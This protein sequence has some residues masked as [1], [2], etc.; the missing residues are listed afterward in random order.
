MLMASFRING[1]AEKDF[2]KWKVS[3]TF[4]VADRSVLYIC[5]RELCGRKFIFDYSIGYIFQK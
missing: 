4:T 1:R 5:T 2:R 3:N